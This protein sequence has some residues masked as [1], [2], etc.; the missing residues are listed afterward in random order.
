V[1]RLTGHRIEVLAGLNVYVPAERGICHA[2]SYPS[3]YLD[4]PLLLLF[5]LE[6]RFPSP[7]RIVN[8]DLCPE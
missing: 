8:D 7:I 3:P 1:A 4:L 6:R 2:S 5:F